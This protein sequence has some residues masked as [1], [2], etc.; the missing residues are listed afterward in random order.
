MPIKTALLLIIG[1]IS[2]SAHALKPHVAKYQLS[3]NGLKIAEEVRTLHQ[4]DDQ[5]FYTA[6]AKTTGIAA[7]VKKYS[8]AASSKFFINQLGVNGINYQIMELEDTQIKDNY[9]I[10][11][12]AK[13]RRVTSNLTKTQP[14]I[15]NWKAK[16]G[17]IVDPLNLFLALAYDL[18]KTPDQVEFHYQV[19][20]GK[21]IEQQHYKKTGNQIINFN[22]KQ[23]NAIK[24]EK[25]SQGTRLEAYFLPEYQYLP[26]S[27]K[28]VKNGR[29][30]HYQIVNFQLDPL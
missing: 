26:I 3:I 2:I 29:D 18:Q 8:V 16:S 13:H 1:I 19:A 23:M 28:Q 12:N 5:Y 21:S 10:D 25:I 27:I 11:I 7:L 4:L 15:K 17:T 6:N 20:N 22:Q 30:Y 24:I 9:S 14:T